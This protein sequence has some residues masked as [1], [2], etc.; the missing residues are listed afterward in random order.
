MAFL[1][2]V[3][4]LIFGGL[5]TGLGWYLAG[6]VM[7]ITIIGLPWAR[8][9]FEIGN[10]TFAPFG[11]RAVTSDEMR[12]ANAFVNRDR[13]QLHGNPALQGLGVIA[14]VL[15][16]P[17]GLLLFLGHAIA[18]LVC[19]ITII[20]IP[21]GLQHFKIA[22]FCLWPVGMRVIDEAGADPIRATASYLRDARR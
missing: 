19:C 8:A 13:S 9:C 1:L 11:K 10:L 21:F 15:W 5:M 12:L 7:A 6:I 3:L 2:N 20:G 22:G 18:G 16:L 17:L 14:A 4:W